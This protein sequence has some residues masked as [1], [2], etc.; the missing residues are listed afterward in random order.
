VNNCPERLKQILF[1]TH[2]VLEGGG[3]KFA[4]RTTK[5]AREHVEKM[6]SEEF[7]RK[8]NEAFASFQTPLQKERKEADSLEGKSYKD[9]EITNK[10]SGSAEQGQEAFSRIAGTVSG[11]DEFRFYSPHRQ[12]DNPQQ[13]TNSEIIQDIRQNPRN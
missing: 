8:I 2:E 10:F 6:S 3:D 5:E 9:I 12:S 7:N 13:K 1:K 4:E 11:H